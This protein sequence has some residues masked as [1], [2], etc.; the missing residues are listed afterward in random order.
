MR[1]YI[2]H[3]MAV[4]GIVAITSCSDDT[5]EHL[6]SGITDSNI[7]T[8]VHMEAR[9]DTGKNVEGGI[10]P[11]KVLPKKWDESGVKPPKKYSAG[12]GDK[13]VVEADIPQ[14]DGGNVNVWWRFKVS[15]TVQ[16]YEWTIGSGTMSK[17]ITNRTKSRTW[18]T[19]K[20]PDKGNTAKEGEFTIEYKVCNSLNKTLCKTM[21]RTV[22]LKK[23]NLAPVVGLQYVNG[24]N[25][26]YTIGIFFDAKDP[27]GKNMTYKVTKVTP[28]GM[29][30]T[31]KI[32]GPPQYVGQASSSA[33]VTNTDLGG[34]DMADAEVGVQVT[35]ADGKSTSKTFKFKINKY[36]ITWKL[37]CGGKKESM[38]MDID[39]TNKL[40]VGVSGY[41]MG[42]GT[43]EANKTASPTQLKGVQ[44][45]W[46]GFGT[47]DKQ[48]VANKNSSYKTLIPTLDTMAKGSCDL[49][50]MKIQ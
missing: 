1:N 37:S 31:W 40:F 41:K 13:V 32:R 33:G 28:T 5:Q 45:T 22:E 16:G 44:N 15:N 20:T 26:G 27:E 11:S 29:G 48:R 4:L 19:G 38:D 18:E 7:D 35:D 47:A 3:L 2:A 25:V 30:G 50:Q 39:I 46:L 21:N 43:Y 6:D 42:P 10:D 34:K 23:G 12:L 8:I 24:G 36:N 9:V 14:G 49:T 17:G